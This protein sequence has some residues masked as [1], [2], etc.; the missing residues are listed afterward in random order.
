[1]SF[2]WLGEVEYLFD[3][4]SPM[5]V[6]LIGHSEEEVAAMARTVID[7]HTDVVEAWYERKCESCDGTGHVRAKPKGWKP[8]KGSWSAW[9]KEGKLFKCPLCHGQHLRV[10][11]VEKLK[12]RSQ[13]A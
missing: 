3:G 4:D 8:A 7:Q 10:S 1:M 2:T 6:A 11:L 12:T 5:P 9:E 13:N